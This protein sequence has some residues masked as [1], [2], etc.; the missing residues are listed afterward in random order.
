MPTAPTPLR[1]AL[2]TTSSSAT[3]PCPPTTTAPAPT[4]RLPAGQS[5]DAFLLDDESK[6]LSFETTSSPG[7]GVAQIAYARSNQSLVVPVSSSAPKAPKRAASGTRPS[8]RT[9]PPPPV[10]SPPP[11][12]TCLPA[13]QLAN[14]CLLDE[15]VGLAATIRSEA[16]AQI[17]KARV[18]QL[19]DVPF[20]SSS[21]K[22]ATPPSPPWGLRSS[23]T[24]SP[25]P[26][27]S[28]AP[29]PVTC[30]AAGQVAVAPLLDEESVGLAA[31]ARSRPATG[32][33]QI[34]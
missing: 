34:A 13:G 20:S 27:P 24:T 3:W 23:S 16:A 29:A 31:T 21:P 7:S 1:S 19:A 32:L 17:A 25:P 4:T 33:A 9:C 14:T 6:G 18:N 12:V 28:S 26:P 30:F 22:T 11:P 8:I 5:A 15:L 2:A 10:M